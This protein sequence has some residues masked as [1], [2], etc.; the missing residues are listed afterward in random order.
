[1]QGV[2]EGGDLSAPAP[3]EHGGGVEEG[4]ED[5]EEGKGGREG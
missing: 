2:R 5:E 4:E 1:M 3:E